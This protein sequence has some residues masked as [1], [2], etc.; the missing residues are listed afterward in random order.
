MTLGSQINKLRQRFG[1]QRLVLV[2]DRGMITQA[3]IDEELRGVEGLDWI[4]ALRSSQIADLAAN[5]LIE[6][7]LFD[8]KN[9]AE[10]SSP[11]F[12]HER[13]MVSRNPLLARSRAH[14]REELLAA[15]EVDLEKSEQPFSA[16]N[17]LCVARPASA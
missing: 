17:G 11:D 12:P 9:L 8:E 14:K 6:P 3:R 5:G 7:S 4:S 16:I 15:T 10:I 1:F 13:L 2:G